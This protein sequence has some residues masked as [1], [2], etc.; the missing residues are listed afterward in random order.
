MAF[1]PSIA[2]PTCKAGPYLMHYQK[3]DGLDIEACFKGIEEEHALGN[4]EVARR[5]VVAAQP[6][7]P[8]R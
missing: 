1:G 7:E 2:K 3:V 8:E 4:C 6:V 5:K